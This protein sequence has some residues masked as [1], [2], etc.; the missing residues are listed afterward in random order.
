MFALDPELPQDV[1]DVLDSASLLEVSEYHVFEMAH[2][3]WFGASATDSDYVRMM[4]RHFFAYLYRDLVPPWVRAFTREVVRS[5]QGEG[6]DPARFGITHAP[7]T[8]TMIYLGIRYAL[9]TL[10]AVAIIF[11]LA[12]LTPAPPGCTF[13]PCY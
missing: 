1:A 10:L 8:P 9:W 12:Y 13:P 7:P 2:A 6:F 3:A 4:E 11:T 5:G